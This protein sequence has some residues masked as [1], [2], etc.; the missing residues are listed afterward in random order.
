MT[1]L[2][3]YRMRILPLVN[4]S[5][6]LLTLFLFSMAHMLFAQSGAG[7]IQGTVKDISGASI[8]NAV[9]V[10]RNTD[11]GQ[12]A[13]TSSNAQG[14]FILPSLFTGNYTLSI[15]SAG[16]AKFVGNIALRVGQT[17]VVDPH[18][19]IETVSQQV[20]VT[21]DITPLASYNDQTISTTLENSRINQLPI[22]GRNLATLVGQVTPGIEGGRANG[23]RESAFEYVQDGTPLENRDFGGATRLP[24]QDSVQE[25][26]VETTDSSAKFNRPATAIITTKAGTNE[27]HGSLF[28]TARNNAFGIAKNR[29]DTF[30]KAPQYIR[31]EFG[32]SVGGPVVIPKIY[33][34]KNKTF[35]FAAYERF[36]L[37]QGVSIPLFVPTMAMRQGNFSGLVD[38]TSGTP[39]VIYDPATSAGRAGNYQRTA[40]PNNKIPL[41]RISPL[42]QKLFALE[43][44]PTNAANPFAASN[45]T[46]SAPSSQTAPTYTARIDQHFNDNN[47]AYLRFTDNRL[48]NTSVFGSGYGGGTAYY[49][50]VLL[51]GA[52]N[53]Q[54]NPTTVDSF[55]M[56]Y[57]H[58]F[59]PTFFAETVL[60]NTWE[61]DVSGGAG[62]QKVDYS[63]Q[64]GL[65]NPFGE[66]SFPGITGT[67]AVGV[68]NQQAS[69]L[70][71]FIYG[72]YRTNSQVTT[73]LDENLT[74]ILGRH[75]L[76]F[77]LRY[78][79]ER[80]GIFPDQ[81]PANQTI[82]N[83]NGTALLNPS[84]ITSNSYTAQP[85]TGLALAD[86]F[87]GSASSYATTL[88]HGYY[89]FRDQEVATYIQDDFHVSPKL[90]LNLGLRWEVH[91]ALHEAHDYIST[92]DL[93]NHAIVLG[94]PLSYYEAIGATTPQVVAALQAA[95]VKFETAQQ[96][97]LPARIIQ[98]NYFTFS[99]RVG[100]AYRVFG[101]RHST[102][103]RGGFG[104]YIYPP[105]LRNFYADNRKN[106]PFFNTFTQDYTS[107]SDS[108][109]GIANYLVRQPQAAVAG[110]NASNVINTGVIQPGIYASG[111]A[112]NYPVTYVQQYNLTLEQQMKP[113]A[114]LRVS[115]LYDRGIHL[116]QYR[117]YN[118]APSNYVYF[119]NTGQPLGTGATASVAQNPY[120]NTTYG[121][122]ELQQKSGYSN[123]NSVQLNYQRLY[124]KGYAFQAYYTFSAAFRNGGNGWRDSFIYPTQDYVNGTPSSSVE[125][126]SRALNYVRDTGIPEHRV[127]MNGLVDL[128]FGSGKRFLSGSSRWLDEI[129]SGWQ[130]AGDATVVSQKFG[131]STTNWG[132]ATLPTVFKHQI[133]VKDCRSGVCLKSYEYFNGYIAPSLVNTAKGVNGLP[134]DFTPDQ[135][136]LNLSNLT[137]TVSV[138]LANG[139]TVSNVAYNPGPGLHP[140]YKTYLN[141]PINWTADAS[142][143]KVL[144]IKEGATLRVN[145]DVFNLFNIQGDNNP[146]ATTGLESFTTSHNVARQLQLTA[147]LSF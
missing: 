25:V 50:P 96:V 26:R 69:I 40:F 37:R 29:Q 78:R 119:T 35:F 12:E 103:V 142:L 108:P 67:G 33:N 111:F 49:G 42:A 57:T 87:L 20:S 130:L 32:A 112:S 131:L 90:V 109:D 94:R 141:G 15:T 140:F 118:T 47:T 7:S 17:A 114:V 59:S 123:D 105:P 73:T 79:H 83:D 113:G 121:T 134:S 129:V 11:T 51:G 1:R 85:Y 92:F 138:K 76:Q 48:Q 99:P 137:N 89:N 136:P 95:G 65:P 122:V 88:N 139:T 13:K 100:F 18:L 61:R 41:S 8:P 66:L 74:K 34:G 91:P 10:A 27:L 22:N 64:F 28:E 60:G 3:V 80:L 70:T 110:L 53:L 104:N 21:G 93:A 31:N 143:F 132:P 126:Q 63:S 101:D 120:D 6:V 125:A 45:Y 81:A 52:A 4:F 16:L 146:D 43:P 144:P 23:N 19:N 133:P 46:T 55:A 71:G 82:F 117:E 72:T 116:E 106:A 9:V 102:V 135:S 14:F 145:V 38:N 75:Q 124:K 128:P 5:V 24:D 36:S 62:N 98:N 86:L 147:R 115:Y 58:V 107:A 30:T 56:S 68:G 39:F 44:A 54:S 77:G 84:T 2:L 127:R 97:N